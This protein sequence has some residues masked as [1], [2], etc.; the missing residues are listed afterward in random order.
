MATDS[1]REDTDL[2]PEGTDM[3]APEVD[4]WFA[5][6]VLP[7]EAILVRFLQ[8]NWRNKSEIADLLQDVY[9]SIY[10]AAPKQI[11]TSPKQFVLTT[12]RNLLIN[13]ARHE[14]I[15]PF[16]AVADMEALGLVADAPGPEQSVM[17][18][19]ELL[20]LQAGLDR[21]PARSREAFV[22]RQ[23]EGLSRHEI[24]LR[25]GI[26]DQTVRWHLNAGLRTLADIMYGESV[27][28]R[29]KA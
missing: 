23:I 14:R 15:V 11:P 8:R 24:A 27:S 20:R 17:A 26:S 25:M 4:A 28:V 3:T 5:R 7:L 6:E 12:A 21:L 13:R 1:S 18:R 9:V 22:L 19:D 10:E 16:E 2:R 29:T